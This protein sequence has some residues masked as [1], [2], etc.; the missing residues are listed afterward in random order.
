MGRLD[1]PQ[2]APYTCGR[3][4]QLAVWTSAGTLAQ[5]VE[6]LTFNQR[7]VDSSSTRPTTE[8]TR[9]VRVFRFSFTRCLAQNGPICPNVAQTFRQVRSA[10]EGEA[11]PLEAREKNNSPPRHTGGYVFLWG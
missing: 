9:L 8:K 7:V 6:Q 11:G 4:A 1:S 2:L 10:G 3:S 5:L